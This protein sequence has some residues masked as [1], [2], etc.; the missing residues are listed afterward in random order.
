M[1]AW[2]QSLLNK[3]QSR[4]AKEMLDNVRKACCVAG[5][6]NLVPKDADVLEVGVCCCWLTRDWLLRCQL[7]GRRPTP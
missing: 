4:W 3:G 1:C 6:M 2:L 5:V 7:W